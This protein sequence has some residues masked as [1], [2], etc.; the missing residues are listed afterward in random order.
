MT[1]KQ[2]DLS[3]K[4]SSDLLAGDQIWEFI[5]LEMLLKGLEYGHIRRVLIESLD[6]P[7]RLQH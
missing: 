4:F 2:L 5:G 7:L 3:L 1:K 6:R